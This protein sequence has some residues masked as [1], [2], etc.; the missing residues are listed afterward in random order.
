SLLAEIRTGWLRLG[1]RRLRVVAVRALVVARGAAVRRALAVLFLDEELGAA[2]GAVPGH[3]PIPQHEVA[4]LGG[5][6]GAA[7]ER[8]PAARARLGGEAAA[9]LARARHAQGDGLGAL[10]LGIGGAGQERAE[11]APLDAHGLAALVAQLVRGLL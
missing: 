10:A 5:V 6:V 11:T 7:V 8:L 9:A 3:G 1:R 4:A 2:L